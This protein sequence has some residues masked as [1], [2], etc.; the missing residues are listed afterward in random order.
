MYY[1]VSLPNAHDRK[2]Y[3]STASDFLDTLDK[4]VWQDY[5]KRWFCTT[6]GLALHPYHFLP[7]GSHR[8]RKLSERTRG[9][10]DIRASPRD[11]C[12]YTRLLLQVKEIIDTYQISSQLM[13][14]P[15]FFWFNV[16]KYYMAIGSGKSLL[17]HQKSGHR[18][19]GRPASYALMG[20]NISHFD[21][22][23]TEVM[24]STH[25]VGLEARPSVLP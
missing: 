21:P 9:R 25:E 1:S 14:S 10:Q 24:M 15:F 2:L 18:S 22:L 17:R 12:Y 6:V 8:L 19:S 11:A 23:A 5:I 7:N 13:L 20:R 4:R 3:V 16:N